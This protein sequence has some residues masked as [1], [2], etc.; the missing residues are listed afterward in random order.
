MEEISAYANAIGV[1]VSSTSSIPDSL[2]GVYISLRPEFVDHIF[3]GLDH[4]T[5]SVK[6]IPSV[7]YI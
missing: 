1:N 2:S 6:L 4:S 5:V 3:K 7:I